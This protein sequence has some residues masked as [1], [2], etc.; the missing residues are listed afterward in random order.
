[1]NETVIRRSDAP[2]FDQGDI[3]VTG[4]GAPTRGSQS[5]AAWQIALEPGAASPE[6]TLTHDEVFIILDGEATFEMEGRRH[7][8]RPGD[9]I[10]VPPDIVFRLRNAGS[11]C[12]TAICCM[13]AGGQAR[14]GDGDPF[15]IPWAQ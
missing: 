7:Q 5:V 13:A 11:E 4:Y 15:P 1:M 14:I 6:H 9:A 2:E 12:F 8:V 10:C 3:M